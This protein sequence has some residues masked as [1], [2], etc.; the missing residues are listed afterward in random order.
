[1][2]GGVLVSVSNRAYE[3]NG[4]RAFRARVAAR[5]LFAGD[6]THALNETGSINPCRDRR[7]LLSGPERTGWPTPRHELCMGK[8]VNLHRCTRR[9]GFGEKEGR[10]APASG[11][12]FVPATGRRRERTTGAFLPRFALLMVSSCMQAWQGELPWR[13]AGDESWASAIVAL[14]WRRSA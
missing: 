6:P 11:F 10:P 13:A 7:V 5:L 12:S 1:L 2:G 3:F 8:R 4:F 9:P 14:H